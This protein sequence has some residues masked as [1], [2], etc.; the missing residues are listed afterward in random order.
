MKKLLITAV[1]IVLNLFVVFAQD[2]LIVTIT[3]TCS[4][5]GGV[6]ELYDTINGKNQYR[7]FYSDISV[8]STYFY[9]S[10]NNTMWVMFGDLYPEVNAFYNTNVPTEMLPPNT[11]WI[12]DIC[13]GTMVIEGGVSLGIEKKLPENNIKYYITSDNILVVELSNLDNQ[14]EV[15]I[16][17]YNLQGQI[18]LSDKNKSSNFE[19]NLNMLK[20]GI[21]IVKISVNNKL[22][23][24]FRILK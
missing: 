19:L 7:M 14:S 5:L 21:Y 15:Q 10:F 24:S 13:D 22:E 3:E 11:G 6:Y 16:D 18:L 23:G 2:S 12:A 4:P 17:L 20:T 9:V 1:A 8:D